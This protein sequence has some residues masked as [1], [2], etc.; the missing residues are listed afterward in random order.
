MN[1]RPEH[2]STDS[3]ME[4]A[5]SAF[6]DALREQVN[7]PLTLMLGTLR[8]SLTDDR[9]PS[10]ERYRVALA[11]RAALRLLNLVDCL[12]D[13]SRIELGLTRASEEVVDLCQVVTDVVSPYED[14]VK[15]AGLRLT[16]DGDE[17][18][19]VV[20]CDRDLLERA[21][22]HLVSNAFKHTRQGEILVRVAR[23]G[24][25]AE[26]SV[27][28]TGI[29]IPEQ[30]LPRVFERFYRVRGAWARTGEASGLGLA[31]VK[32]VAESHGGAVRV[33]SRPGIGSSFTISLPVAPAGAR[34]PSPGRLADRADDVVPGHHP[35]QEMLACP[36][37]G[38]PVHRV[39]VRVG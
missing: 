26:V 9:L 7:T 24:E 30:E 21:L 13:L 27:L 1:I 12:D 34:V 18:G 5:R 32:A 36:G 35:L 29:G 10:E 2:G 28:D 17:S 4:Q 37:G 39:P 38:H 25:A 14:V 8:E 11:H 23:V 31:L 6:I 22:L 16:V 33:E 19:A 20:W 15:L 3:E